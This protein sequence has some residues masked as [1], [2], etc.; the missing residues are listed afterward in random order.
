RERAP[1]TKQQHLD[2][3]GGRSE[4]LGDL[5]VGETV[6]LAEED[7]AALRLRDARQRVVEP[8]ELVVLRLSLRDDLLEHVRISLVLRAPASRR[9]AP[10]GAADV[11]RDRKEPGGLQLRDDAA[12]QRAERVPEDRLRRVLR[13]DTSAE[14]TAA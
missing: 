7:R 5:P 6:P 8:E 3:G 11:V 9:T 10:V 13:L 2:S 14:L 1:C 12:S 4:L